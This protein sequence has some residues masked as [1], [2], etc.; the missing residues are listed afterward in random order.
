[1]KITEIDKNFK[2]KDVLR[3]GMQLFNVKDEPFRLYGFLEPYRR[4]PEATAK[5]M[6]GGAY[7]LHTNTAGGRV[8]FRTDSDYVVLKSVLP[9]TCIMPQ[10]T[11]DGSC[12]FDMYA[13]VRNCGFRGEVCLSG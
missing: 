13:F 3:P 5:A 12:G 4:I 8:R 2:N 10:M 11:A 7:F 6:S 1:M 9:Y